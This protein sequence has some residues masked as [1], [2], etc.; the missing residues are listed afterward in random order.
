M[1]TIFRFPGKWDNWKLI[2]WTWQV[3]YGSESHYRCPLLRKFTNYCA[4]FT[5]YMYCT[6]VA[7]QK[8]VNHDDRAACTGILGF[9]CILRYNTT[10]CGGNQKN[11]TEMSVYIIFKQNIYNHEIYQV[12]MYTTGVSWLE[13]G[14]HSQVHSPVACMHMIKITSCQ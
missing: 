9:P 1:T 3:N 10:N 13:A 8:L 2:K 14:A 11:C 6:A 4:A 12:T 7:T 5:K